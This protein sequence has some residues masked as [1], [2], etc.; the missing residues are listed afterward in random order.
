MSMMF[1][2][3]LLGSAC[4]VAGCTHVASPPP[5]AV[6]TASAAVETPIGVT[7]RN[8][9]VPIIDAHQ[10][11]MGPGALDLLKRVPSPPPVAAPAALADLLSAREKGVDEANYAT[12]FTEDA[13]LFAEEQG[14]WWTG[15]ERILDALG[16]FGSELR[17][18]PTS[19]AMDG[20][21]G[22]V[23]GILRTASGE[24]THNFVIG[25]RKAADG[26]WRIASE[27]KQEMA[28][29]TYGQSPI[30]AERIIEVMDD[31]GIRYA[32]VLS[33]AYWFGDPEKPIADRWA[34]TR[35]ENDWVIAQT[36]KYPDR[37][38]PFCGVNPID[39]YAIAELERC[40]ALG[41]R[42]MKIHRNSKFRTSNPEHLEKLK[43]FFR[44]A[45]KH[46][47]AIVI[48]LRDTPEKFIDEILPEAPDVAIQ[49]AHMGSG[50]LE[51]FADAIAAGKPGTKNLWFDWTQALPIEDLWMH[52]RPGGRI[53]GPVEP[54]ERERM[55]GLM[56]KIG[57]GRVLYGTDMPLPWNP[58]PREWWRKTI[59]TLPLTDDEIRD[60]ADN[61]PPYVR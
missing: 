61:L 60:I 14:R 17:F 16:N 6:G 45:N 36:R 41:V 18:V 25:V 32:T 49:I 57:L 29:S 48:H 26:R 15:K 1:K 7:T 35:A 13:L 38:I 43:Q 44:A 23:A 10:H 5:A 30:T 51:L 24:D 9:I 22:Y 21:A 28:P 20:A 2:A 53:G 54:G 11:M 3:I 8:Q 46:G 12:M 19:Y 37:L 27:M 52:G 34:G 31:A 42:G 56:R 50:T 40:A 59:L 55:V 39:D 47:L 33:V 4:L 58:T